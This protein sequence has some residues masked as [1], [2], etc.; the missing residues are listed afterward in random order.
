MDRPPIRVLVAVADRPEAARVEALLLSSPPAKYQLDHAATPDRTLT[1]LCSGAFDV[2][3]LDGTLDQHDGVTLVREAR[4]T[5][6]FIP[7]IVLSDHAAGGAD[8]AAIQVGAA[9]WL[10][11]SN[12]TPELLHRATR[13]AV[14][15]SRT[16]LA[17]HESERRKS[18]VL[19]A[20]LDAIVSI[21]VTGRFVEFNAAAE[22]TFGFTRDEAVGR[23]MV[24]MIV[25]PS[26]RDAHRAGFAHH[27][28]TGEGP[29]I[30]RRIEIVGCR[31]DGSEFPIELTITR[32][33]LV[34]GPIFSAQIRDITERKAAAAALWESETRARDF[35]EQASHGMYR[36]S[37]EGRFLSANP[38]LVTMLGCQSEADVLSLNL[39]RDVFADP[40]DR[41]AFL[42]DLRRTQASCDGE[43]VWRR[44]NGEL[45][46][47][48]LR[49]RP[50]LAKNGQLEIVEAVVEDITERKRLE[51]QLLQ[52]QKMETV[53]QLA[54]GIAHDFNNL[55]TAILGYGDLL[56]DEMQ[57]GDP[58]REDLGEIRRA[59]ERAA[60][61]TRQLLAFSRQQ[62]LRPIAMDLNAVI[63]GLA[64]M[65]RRL[66][67]EHI[68]V[69]LRLEPDLK[70]I[71]ADPGQIEQVI[72]NLA[73]NA[74]D[75]MPGGG[76]IIFETQATLVND[77][78]ARLMDL[79]PGRYAL[80]GVT[81]SGVGMTPEV[82]A[83][84]FEPFF[85]TKDAG[86]GT[87]LGLATVY[88]IVKQSNGHVAVVSTPGEGTTFSLY[89]PQTTAPIAKTQETR[90]VSARGS[91]T[92]LLVEDESSVRALAAEVLRRNGYHVL[93]A[94][95]GDGALEVAE[96]TTDPIH[97][98]LTDVVMRGM[99]GKEL[100][101][102]LLTTRPDTR[103]L[104]MSGYTDE[105]IVHHGVLDEGTEFLQKPFTRDVLMQRV[106]QVLDK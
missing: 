95:H 67:G 40:A 45:R 98:L 55:L 16:L 83:H 54:G 64:L 26:F 46:T 20:A 63:S 29:L 90:T 81:D 73:V 71:L 38:A 102:R 4:A 59:A 68:H 74:R 53:G 105:A 50:V 49:G 43:F 7:I 93:T 34:A 12:L 92:I 1:M 30:G 2:C 35:V 31:A 69:A 99:S 5:G 104:F 89:F 87:G 75:A 65:I 56:L 106:R 76:S 9:D 6:C 103:V 97:L 33:Q 91:E 41:R 66:I 15:R 77:L 47:V 22:R 86:K 13:Y 36:A 60:A 17:L 62:I 48:H 58:R 52:A 21:D 51:H 11:K 32:T 3:L 70:P 44:R 28:A 78:D 100:A 42:E 39:E 19:D 85:T 8:A 23:L 25:P 88:G 82:L 18:A 10:I 101:N 94:D 57:P 61:L 96:A 72:V 37:V 84:I 80:L 27:L 24:D 14:E 79:R